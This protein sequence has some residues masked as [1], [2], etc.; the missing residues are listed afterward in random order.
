MTRKA[1]LEKYKRKTKSGAGRRKESGGGG[2]IFVL[3]CLDY[4]CHEGIS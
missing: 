3:L 1:Y 2:R 4:N